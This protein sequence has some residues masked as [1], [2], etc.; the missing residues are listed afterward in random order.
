MQRFLRFSGSSALRSYSSSGLIWVVLRLSALRC[1]RSNVVGSLSNDQ[2]SAVARSVTVTAWVWRQQQ[3]SF[4]VLYHSDLGSFS[5]QIRHEL[6]RHRD[7]I[8]PTWVFKCDPSVTGGLGLLTAAV[9]ALTA[10]AEDQYERTGYS[11]VSRPAGDAERFYEFEEVA[12][13]LLN[14][15]FWFVFGLLKYVRH[16]LTETT[17]AMVKRASD[18]L[19]KLASIQVS[20]V[21]ETYLHSIILKF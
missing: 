9:V 16:D 6:S 11:E 1:V 12:V 17:R 14:W 3:A 8:C 13:S 20:L 21:N 4:S 15:C 5:S 2:S 10:S 19:K 18:D 7:R